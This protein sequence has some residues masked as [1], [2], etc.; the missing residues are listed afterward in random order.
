[1][2]Q[3]RLRPWG[4]LLFALIGV[5]VLS[6]AAFLGPRP[7]PS[8]PLPERPQELD[9][10]PR[11]PRAE[12]EEAIAWRV[13][14]M[15]DEHGQIPDGA[16]MR[17]TEQVHA[18]RA[19]QAR[20]SQFSAASALSWTSLGPSNVGGRVRSIAIHPSDA[21]TMFAGS[22]GGGIWKTTNGGEIGRAHV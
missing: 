16:L 4:P 5:S 3:N 6:L 11:G 18:M 15:R 14:R 13:M 22:V 8:L 12:G 17:A 19:A 2:P 21:N 20:Q 9:D 7:V 10:D 1:M